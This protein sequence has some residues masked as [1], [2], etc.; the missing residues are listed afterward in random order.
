LKTCYGC[1]EQKDADSFYKDKSHPSGLSGYCKE[2][3][4]AILLDAWVEDVK[5]NIVWD[6]DGRH[7]KMC[8]VFV[9]L[10]EMHLDHIVPLSRGGKHSYVNTQTLCGPC[11]LYKGVRTLEELGVLPNG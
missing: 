3:S 8:Q 6:R 10:E 11:N 9:S 2:C 1:K 5:R 4:R 7:C